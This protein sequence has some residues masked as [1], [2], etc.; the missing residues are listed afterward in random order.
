MLNVR[1]VTEFKPSPVMLVSQWSVKMA[2]QIY[3][4]QLTLNHNFT[5]EIYTLYMYVILQINR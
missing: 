1:C 5:I 3:K 2:K 4:L